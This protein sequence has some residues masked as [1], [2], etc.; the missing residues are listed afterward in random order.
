MNLLPILSGFLA[1][2]MLSVTPAARLSLGPHDFGPYPQ[3]FRIAVNPDLI[4]E[5]RQK[6]QQYRPSLDLDHESSQDWSDGPPAASVTA[7][8]KYWAEDYKWE[9]IQDKMNSEFS[10]FTI[11]IPAVSGYEASTPLHFVH[12]RSTDD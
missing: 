8:A 9:E 1:I 10:H 2:I 4:R 7:L 3:P 5:T 11:R 12:E 6:A